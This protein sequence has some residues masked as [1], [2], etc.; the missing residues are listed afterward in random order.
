MA[1]GGTVEDLEKNLGSSTDS[2]KKQA[3]KDQISYRKL[4][5]QQTHFESKIF[6]AGATVEGRYQLYSIDKLKDNLKQV[7]EFNQQAAGQRAQEIQNPEIRPEVERR[8]KIDTVKKVMK[9][10]PRDKVTTTKEASSKKQNHK[11]VG[12]YIKHKCNHSWLNAKVVR[13]IGTEVV[14]TVILR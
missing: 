7:I 14:M 13:L 10:V 2:E 11:L 9:E 12:K 8:T 1:S 4:V 6:N 5:L 3:L